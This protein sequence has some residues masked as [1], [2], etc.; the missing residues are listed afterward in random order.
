[1]ARPLRRSKYKPPNTIEAP[2]PTR[3]AIHRKVKREGTSITYQTIR[4]SSAAR[5][6]CDD[7]V[8]V[9]TLRR[10]NQ[11]FQIP[12]KLLYTDMY[13]DTSRGKEVRS[14]K[15]NQTIRWHVN[16]GRLSPF[17]CG[18]EYDNSRT[19]RLHDKTLRLPQHKPTNQ[20]PIPASMAMQPQVQM[21]RK[22]KLQQYQTIR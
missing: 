18:G 22:L 8:N 5:C 17:D 15:L 14:L 13:I 4:R 19:L 2:I 1:M 10:H 9:Q 20:A 12:T 16:G 6:L 11:S 3:V 21:D 7:Y